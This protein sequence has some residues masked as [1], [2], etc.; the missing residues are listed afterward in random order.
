MTSRPSTSIIPT[1]ACKNP[2]KALLA[3]ASPLAPG[4]RRALNRAYVDESEA[5]GATRGERV[6][7]R[8][9]R[10]DTDRED[11]GERVITPPVIIRPTPRGGPSCFGGSGSGSGSFGLRSGGSA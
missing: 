1:A 11:E 5:C 2:C 9:L 10:P 3:A 8:R 7:L 4:P 6:L